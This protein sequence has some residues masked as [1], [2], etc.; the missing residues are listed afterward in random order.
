MNLNEILKSK[1]I[2]EEVIKSILEDMKANN[3]FTASEE[4]LDI[5]YGKLKNQHDTASAQL[6]EANTLEKVFTKTE[7]KA[8]ANLENRLKGMG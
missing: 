6:K 7:P 2:E 4:N 5:R 1:N 3:I 8:I